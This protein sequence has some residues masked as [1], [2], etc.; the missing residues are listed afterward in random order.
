MLKIENLN[1]SFG[2]KEVLKNINF[3][4]EKGERVV[5]LGESGSGKSTI[6]R[7]INKLEEKTSGAIY[8]NNEL[9]TDKNILKVRSKINMVFQSYNLFNNL[10]ILENIILAP[11]K[12]KMLSEIK[13]IKEAEKLLDKFN[14]SEK[15]NDY[16]KQLSG[17]QKQRVAIIRALIMNPEYI[18]F[19]EPTSALDPKMIDEVVEIFRELKKENIGMI[20]VTHEL[21]FAREIADRVLF[22]HKGKIIED[23]PK[24][25]IFYK[26]KTREL[27]E[28]LSP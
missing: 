17:G 24:E 5:I 6:L 11:V 8:F 23:G 13:A 2:N 21:K 1:K 22:I 10:T 20:V 3:N 25:E 19:D 18:L 7:C 9:I 12:L 14:L 27:K 26:P 15:I 4:L 28:F 16:P